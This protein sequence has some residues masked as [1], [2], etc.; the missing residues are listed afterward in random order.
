MMKPIHYPRNISLAAVMSVLVTLTPVMAADKSKAGPSM[1]E[2][3][4]TLQKSFENVKFE[5]VSPSGIWP[6]LYEV[7]T[8][9]ELVY[10]NANGS[11][12]FTGRILD[13]ETKTD[14]TGKSWNDLNKVDFNGLPFENAIKIVRGDGSRKLA[15]FADPMCPYCKALEKNLQDTTN[16]TIYLFL[17]PLESIH[18]GASLLSGAVWCAADPAAVWGGWMKDGQAPDM[19]ADCS[20]TPIQQNAELASRIKINST[21]TMIFSDGGRQMGS[22]NAEQ[23]ERRLSAAV[24]K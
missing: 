19:S 11:L 22:I 8:E 10:T 23:L 15:L 4:A 17:F 24:S 14:L 2:I 5:K 21:P 20:S 6:G 13:T 18:P 12:L 16:I 7:V 3:K 1:D 9:N